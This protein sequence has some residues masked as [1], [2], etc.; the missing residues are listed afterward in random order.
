M[1]ISYIIGYIIYRYNNYHIYF[2]YIVTVILESVLWCQLQPFKDLATVTKKPREL[3][4]Q[5]N[6]ADVLLH[7]MPYY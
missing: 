6:I 5:T 7:H 4:N 2:S 3:G 1:N